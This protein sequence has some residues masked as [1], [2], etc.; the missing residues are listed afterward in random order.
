MLDL[1]L[2]LALQ[3]TLASDKPGGRLLAF[4]LYNTGVDGCL[5]AAV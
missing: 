4:D 1:L 3:N 2:G 5:Q